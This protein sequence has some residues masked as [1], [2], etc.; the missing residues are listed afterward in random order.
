[1]VSSAFVSFL[2]A[3]VAQ[4]AGS[5]AYGCG[6]QHN[7]T[8]NWT[9]AVAMAESFT[10]KLTFQEKLNIVTGNSPVN[11]CIGNIAAVSS[12]GFNALCMVDGPN[13]VGRTDRVSVFP[14]GITTAAT[15]DKR[16]MYLRGFVLG[17]EA[18]GFGAHV[19]LA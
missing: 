3:V 14:S 19:L 16:L 4:A 13:A 5:S 7:G 12:L 8:L 1:M 6:A 2:V 18:K 15:W 9:E 17:S 11:V 10:A